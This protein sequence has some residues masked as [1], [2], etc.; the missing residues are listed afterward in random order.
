M[1]KTISTIKSLN[2]VHQ[3]V[4]RLEKVILLSK[5]KTEITKAFKDLI[6]I[7]TGNCICDSCP[8]W[9]K[10]TYIVYEFGRCLVP[11]RFLQLVK[12]LHLKSNRWEYIQPLYREF[13]AILYADLNPET[14]ILSN[15]DMEDQKC[16]FQMSK[17]LVEAAGKELEKVQKLNM[18][19]IRKIFNKQ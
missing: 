8:E 13:Y 3:E 5:K 19:N 7:V 18:K 15:G 11:S 17:E 10:D 12:E 2:E 1:S 9:D 6:C 4:N 14:G 16:T